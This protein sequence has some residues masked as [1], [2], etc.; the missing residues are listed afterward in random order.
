MPP[1][2]SKAQG[3]AKGKGKAKADPTSE[4]VQQRAEKID[5]G[6]TLAAKY[7]LGWG[8]VQYWKS[9]PSP[10]CWAFG[11]H[12]PRDLDEAGIN[13]LKV[14]FGG[15]E[16]IDNPVDRAVPLGISPRSLANPED[17]TKNSPTRT[18]QIE[19]VHWNDNIKFEGI[20]VFNGRVRLST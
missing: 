16:F 2:A 7:F 8:L 17:L 20:Q 4:D 9:D 11:I 1:K 12:N 19:K 15:S 10:E 6:K 3:P 5:E 18:D 14:A 13:Q